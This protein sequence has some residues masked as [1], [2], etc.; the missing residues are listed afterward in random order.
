VKITLSGPFLEE[1][2]DTRIFQRGGLPTRL[3]VDPKFSKRQWLHESV[4]QQPATGTPFDRMT[5]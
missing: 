1:P 4:S 2:I 5:A 3:P